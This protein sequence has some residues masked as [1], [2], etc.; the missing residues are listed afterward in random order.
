M[1]ESENRLYGLTR[2]FRNGLDMTATLNLLKCFRHFA[3]AATRIACAVVS[4]MGILL[5]STA[6]ASAPIHD[7][8]Q[9]QQTPKAYA[10]AV[11]PLDEYRCLNKLYYYESRWN[12]KAKN[13]SHYG[14]PQ[15]RSEWLRTATPIQQVKWGIKYNRARYSDQCKALEHFKKNNW[16]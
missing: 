10:K 8:I 1:T 6:N 2:A 5:L 12:H 4:V 7:G 15:G 11:L 16:H 14:I 13:G 9:I 3:Q